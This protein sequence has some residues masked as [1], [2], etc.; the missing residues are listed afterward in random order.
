MILPSIAWLLILTSA[1]ALTFASNTQSDSWSNQWHM[2]MWWGAKWMWFWMK[3]WT[4]WM[5]NLSDTNREALMDATEIA[6]KAKDY[7]AF[8]EAH[9]KYGITLNMTE[10]QF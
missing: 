4:E 3:W 8:K 6:I 9:T 7:E 10:D 2:R 1:W 5:Q